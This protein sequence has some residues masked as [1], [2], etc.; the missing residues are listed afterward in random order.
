MS[1]LPLKAVVLGFGPQRLQSARSG[2]NLFGQRRRS[3]RIQRPLPINR[4]ENQPIEKFQ[5]NAQ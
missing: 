4:I 2:H 1:A 3:S 5:R